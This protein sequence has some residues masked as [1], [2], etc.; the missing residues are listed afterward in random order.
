MEVAR[1]LA[2]ERRPK[3]K[4]ARALGGL[5]RSGPKPQFDPPIYLT[6]IAGGRTGHRAGDQRHAH[7]SPRQDAAQPYAQCV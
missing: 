7:A 1:A 4:Q 2:E 3:K 6:R 5:D